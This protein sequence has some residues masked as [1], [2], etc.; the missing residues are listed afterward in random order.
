MASSQDL[1]SSTRPLACAKRVLTRMQ[2][3]L[4]LT[5]GTISGA[6]AAMK[7]HTQHVSRR[8]LTTCQ[9]L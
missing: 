9:P 3:A 6:A 7:Q 2:V 8:A 5:F 1:N 4:R